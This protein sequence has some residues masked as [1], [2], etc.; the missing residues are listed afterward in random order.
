M[1]METMK[2]EVLELMCREHV[3]LRLVQK[4][5]LRYTVHVPLNGGIL[6]GSWRLAFIEWLWAPSA[7][8][9]SRAHLSE[10]V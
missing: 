8:H 9:Y 1:L 5:E 2:L 3:F 6:G 10:D 4:P 7:A